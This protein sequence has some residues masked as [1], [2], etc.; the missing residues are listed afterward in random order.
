MTIGD[1]TTAGSIGA[2]IGAAGGTA[3]SSSSSSAGGLFGPSSILSLSSSAQSDPAVPDLT[4]LVS[5]ALAF[6]QPQA[7]GFDQEQADQFKQ[8]L[9]L[10]SGGD[11]AGAQTILDQLHQQDP[12]NGTV[13]HAMGTVAF[14][15]NDYAKAAKLFQQSDFLAPGRG[16]D[17][18][19]QNA[20][21]LQQDDGKVLSAAKR[22]LAGSDTADQGQR[23]LVALT[24]RSPSNADAQ[25]TLAESF[26]KSGDAVN[27][28]LRYQQAIE[29]GDPDQLKQIE[30]R[31][32]QLADLSPKAAFVHDLLGK[33]QLKLGE[34]SDAEKSF[35]TAASL[36]EDPTTY[37]SDLAD[38]Y[39]SEAQNKLS[40]SDIP[41]A[42]D[43][44]Y[45]AQILAPDNDNLKQ[46]FVDAYS[47]R[48]AQH[49]HDNDLTDAV[50]DYQSAIA[51]L[52][53]N[54]TDQQ[55]LN[56]AN[57]IYSV[58]RLIEA[59][60]GDDPVGLEASAFQSAYDLVPDNQTFKTKLA[61]TRELAGDQF[62]AENNYTDAIGAY[63]RAD[64]LFPGNSTYKNAFVS[65]LETDGDN[66]MAIADYGAA[67]DSYKEAY[68]TDK[69]NLDNKQTLADAYN[70]RGQN[71]MTLGEYD[72][73][74][75]DFQQ[76]MSLYPNNEDYQNNYNDASNPPPV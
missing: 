37:N 28:L 4:S 33:A 16:Y 12:L 58:G 31:M 76:A 60:R 52:S 63:R 32:S 13:I 23:L 75:A 56:L 62:L 38:A 1:S 25:M 39:V 8:A 26:L 3:S 11:S 69:S 42:F 72:L 36:A 5:S 57:D 67:I 22:M 20:K 45:Q 10:E 55:K 7:H 30:T 24:A 53:S 18:D 21:L 49:V 71:Y 43:R 54:A 59:K 34:V 6:Q 27:G 48:A 44:L 19:A 50:T 40:A 35:Q 17:S 68:D 51:N 64:Y 73:A 66:N 2:L 9:A 29:N 74:A 46:A 70:T 15:G 65:T 14:D 47:A 61:A 41:G